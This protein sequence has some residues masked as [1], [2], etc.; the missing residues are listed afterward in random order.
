MSLKIDKNGT[1]YDE[2][3]PDN[4]IFTSEMSICYTLLTDDIRKG[5]RVAST[6][7][8]DREDALIKDGERYIAK[9]TDSEVTVSETPSGIK[10]DIEGKNELVSEYGINL[11][12][13][14]MGKKNGGGWQNQFLFNSP[15]VSHDKRYIYA[16]LTKE[17]GCNLAV[18]VLSD[19]DGWKMDYSPYSFGHF[20]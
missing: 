8:V 5:K 20:L 3:C 11:P 19:A 9:N 12:F 1:I 7:Y 4:K 13:N 18:A 15:Y 14:F 17:N 6:P 2:R 10:I 16:Y